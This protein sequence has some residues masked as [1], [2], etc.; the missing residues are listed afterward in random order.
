MP[1]GNCRVF[2]L[3]LIHDMLSVVLSQTVV[4]IIFVILRRNFISFFI[5]SQNLNLNSLADLLMDTYKWTKASSWFH[6]L[7]NTSDKYSPTFTS[8]HLFF[9][10]KNYASSLLLVSGF[11]TMDLVP[12]V[13]P[14]ETPISYY[15]FFVC[16]MC[17]GKFSSWLISI[18]KIIVNKYFF[19]YNG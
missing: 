2:I 17:F 1:T 4:H 11:I 8:M 18:K 5:L 12:R 19:W 15:F 6:H 14:S 10:P 3:I 9:C 7:F 13:S 16:S